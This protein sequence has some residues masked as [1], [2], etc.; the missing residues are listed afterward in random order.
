M[1]ERITIPEEGDWG[2]AYPVLHTFLHTGSVSSASA[3][4]FAAK[5][6]RRATRRALRR[7][8]AAPP[9]PPLTA[10]GP[11]CCALCGR[12]ETKGSRPPRDGLCAHP[13]PPHPSPGRA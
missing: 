11:R 7:C 3:A 12:H 1:L 13:E 9:H 6:A 10:P 8:A 2:D 5:Q 4:A